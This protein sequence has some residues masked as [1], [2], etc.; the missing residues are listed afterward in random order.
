M[1]IPANNHMERGGRPVK[2]R[3]TIEITPLMMTCQPMATYFSGDCFRRRFQRA[4]RTAE[5]NNNP[6][7][8]MGMQN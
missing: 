3:K 2:K 6:M 4:C 7:A 1:L 8:R 5:V